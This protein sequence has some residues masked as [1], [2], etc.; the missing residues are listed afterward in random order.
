MTLPR[1]WVGGF[2]QRLKGHGFV[3]TP[4]PWCE[5]TN[6]KIHS[7][8]DTCSPSAV[9][10]VDPRDSTLALSREVRAICCDVEHT[11]T[12]SPYHIYQMQGVKG[13]QVTT[14]LLVPD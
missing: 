7:I 9:M 12:I 5:V 13:L 3:P 1:I 14:A 6:T 4:Q 2:Q 11:H 10:S 8:Q